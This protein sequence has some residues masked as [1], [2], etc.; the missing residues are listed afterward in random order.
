MGKQQ[1]EFEIY[2]RLSLLA[3]DIY[4]SDDQIDILKNDRDLFFKIKPRRKISLAFS[5]LYLL[6]RDESE[7]S[8]HIWESIALA[9]LSTRKFNHHLS[10]S[11]VCFLLSLAEKN[12]NLLQSQESFDFLE[13]LKRFIAF[14]G[15]LIDESH[16]VSLAELSE[17]ER[18]GGHKFHFQL[19]YLLINLTDEDKKILIARTKQDFLDLL[20]ITYGI[21]PFIS[22]NDEAMQISDGSNNMVKYLQSTEI[23]KET[24]KESNSDQEDKIEEFSEEFWETLDAYLAK[25]LNK[26]KLSVSNQEIMKKY[27]ETLD[28]YTGLLEPFSEF[29][30][31][32]SVKD[33]KDSLLSE[34]SKLIYDK[35][36]DFVNIYSNISGILI[37]D[38]ESPKIQPTLNTILLI[39]T[40]LNSIKKHIEGRIRLEKCLD[41]EMN[42]NAPDEFKEKV[43][44][45]IT[46]HWK[47]NDNYAKNNYFGVSVTDIQNILFLTNPKSIKNAASDKSSK[48]EFYDDSKKSLTYES[49][50]DWLKD[51]ERFNRMYEFTS[52]KSFP[53]DKI[54][55]DSLKTFL[56]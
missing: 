21:R 2:K 3:S 31:S 7:L 45:K 56:K 36:S 29:T 22:N 6:L 4:E 12:N 20:L 30:K 49:S 14:N 47:V 34:L 52:Q 16:K 53:K 26:S 18:L 37:E 33:N 50:V 55:L 24:I 17:E 5:T 38:F 41:T 54:T 48:L 10:L 19:Q 40:W 35:D 28:S 46:E 11:E 39:S 32:T 15:L 44:Y 13:N 23:L 51:S 25:Y 27:L 1:D 8:N 43:L 9:K 42:I